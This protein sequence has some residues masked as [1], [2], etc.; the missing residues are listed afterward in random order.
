MLILDVNEA[1][2]QLAMTNGVRWYGHVL[3]RE[4]AHILRMVLVLV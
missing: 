3:R 1:I 2:D 4:D